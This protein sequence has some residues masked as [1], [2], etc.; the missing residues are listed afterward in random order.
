MISSI[1]EKPLQKVEIEAGLYKVCKSIRISNVSE[2]KY[3][4]EDYLYLYFKSKKSGGGT[5]VVE[6]CELLGN[7]EAV[8]SFV[9]PKGIVTA[10]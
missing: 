4:S 7:G 9:D 3:Y 5:K 2:R 6:S 8:V 10:A 1:K